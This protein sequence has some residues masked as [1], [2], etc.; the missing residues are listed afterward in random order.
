[1]RSLQDIKSDRLAFRATLIAMLVGWGVL[2]LVDLAQM[3]GLDATNSY[4]QGFSWGLLLSSGVALFMPYLILGL[5][6]AWL[7]TYWTI[8]PIWRSAMTQN[9]FTQGYVIGTGTVFGAAIGLLGLFG[10]PTLLLFG[11]DVF[12]RLIMLALDW[13]STTSAGALGGLMAWRWAAPKLPK[14]EDVF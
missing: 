3:V 1:M 14:M 10:F 11:L 7:V 12:P 4:S 5:P 13:F 8:R 2:Y 6:I 9:R